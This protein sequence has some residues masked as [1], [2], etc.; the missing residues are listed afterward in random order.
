LGGLLLLIWTFSRSAWLGASL[1]FLLFAIQA[2]RK[3]LA[4]RLKK[5]LLW[6]GALSV[7]GLGILFFS[8]QNWIAILGRAES[9]IQHFER[10]REAF[11]L[12]LDNP[13][14]FGLGKTGGVSQRFDNPITPENTYLGI[15]LELG[16]LVGI[17]FLIF[18]VQLLLELRKQNSELFYSLIGILV[19]AF[20][21]HPL[22]DSPTALS[23]F[24]LAG[25]LNSPK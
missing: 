23:L 8:N 12:V 1:I 6:G 13:L 24:L 21:L 9:S 10:S 3:N 5:K 22:E 2:W 11:E 4:L 19:V 16:W 17:L 25:V 20:F 18:I 7:L 15:T 14:G